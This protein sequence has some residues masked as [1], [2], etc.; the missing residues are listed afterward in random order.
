MNHS[1]FAISRPGDTTIPM[2]S[3]LLMVQDCGQLSE[4][5]L[6]DLD[7]KHWLAFA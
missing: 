7:G 1:W 5:R 4:C 6:E 2:E 3:C